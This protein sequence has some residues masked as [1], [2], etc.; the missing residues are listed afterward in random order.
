MASLDL[1]VDINSSGH[2]Y[3]VKIQI[4]HSDLST[5]DISSQIDSN[6]NLSLVTINRGVLMEVPL[7]QKT[8]KKGERLR[9]IITLN[10]GGGTTLRLKHNGSE[11]KIDI[12]FRIES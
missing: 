10:E 4:V 6:A 2:S 1:K 12:P 5:T 3:S 9:A 7:T 8:I 11:S